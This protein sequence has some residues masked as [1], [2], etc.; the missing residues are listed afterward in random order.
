[1]CLTSVTR[2][3]FLHSFIKAS[4]LK[5]A[6]INTHTRF[7]LSHCFDQVT[8]AENFERVCGIGFDFCLNYFHVQQHAAT[9]FAVIHRAT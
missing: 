1:M 5:I 4:L 7:L 3:K 9:V 6:E 2:E 8:T